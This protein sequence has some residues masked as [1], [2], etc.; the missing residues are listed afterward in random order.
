[1]VIEV[2]L[3]VSK[4]E[5][6]MLPL[7]HAVQKTL[8][9]VVTHPDN[10]MEVGTLLRLTVVYHLYQGIVCPDTAESTNQP[11]STISRSHEERDMTASQSRE[12]VSSYR[13]PWQHA[14]QA[15]VPAHLISACAPVEGAHPL[16]L[17]APLAPVEEPR[18]EV[19]MRFS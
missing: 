15:N 19:G 7:F 2:C 5:R 3:Q 13:A 17:P 12:S 16:L 9:D 14:R 1:M 4:A 6:V 10:L 18:V 8:P 11:M